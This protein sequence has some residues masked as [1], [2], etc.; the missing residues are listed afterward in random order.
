T[1]QASDAAA[2]QAGELAA[3]AGELCD[4]A[5]SLEGL[6]GVAPA[7][8]PARSRAPT[9]SRT[10][11]RRPAGGATKRTLPRAAAPHPNP[12]TRPADAARRLRDEYRLESDD[13]VET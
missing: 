4:L 13:L 5:G 1:A 6:V 10:P 12:R 11:A 3:Q 8:A 7:A 2:E 9:R